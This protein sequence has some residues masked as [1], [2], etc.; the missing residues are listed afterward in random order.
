MRDQVMYIV[1]NDIPLNNFMT[2]IL[3][4]TLYDMNICTYAKA[5]CR[6]T[7]NLSYPQSYRKCFIIMLL[8]CVGVHSYAAEC[9]CNKQYLIPDRLYFL[10]CYH[11]KVKETNSHT[12]HQSPN[13]YKGNSCQIPIF[14]TY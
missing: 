12:T 8:S 4:N 11:V 14:G 13:A 2:N 1:M 7:T 9:P 3:Q 6:E 5:F 10:S